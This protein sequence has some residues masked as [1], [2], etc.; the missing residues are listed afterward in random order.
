M[1]FVCTPAVLRLIGDSI[2]RAAD[3]GVD[4]PVLA[5][6]LVVSLISG[7][8]F[9]I[10]PALTA[11]KTDLVSTLKEGGYSDIPSHDW[12]RSTVIVGQVALG[13]VLT[14]GAG[15]LVTSFVKLMRMNEG[16]NP[17]RLLTFTFELPDSAYKDKRPEF[18]RQYFEKLRALPGVQSAAGA[19]NLPM[20]DNLAMI[21]F[22]NPEH[23]VPKGQQP[24]ADFTYVSADYFRTLQVPLLYGRAFSDSDDMKAP[25]VMIVNRAFVQ[26]YFPGGNVL[27]KKLKPGATNGMPGGPP[28]R[29]IVG[30]VDNIRHFGTQREMPPAMYLPVGQLPTWCCLRFVV[31]TSMDPMRLE[32]AVRRLVSSLDPNLPV[33]EVRSMDDLLSLQLAQPRIAMILLGTFAGLALLLTMV[34]LYGVMAYSVSRRTREIG[35]RLA[36]GAQRSA[37]MAMVLRDAAVLLLVGIAFGAAA[38]FAS[39]SAL[40]T[41]L[42]SVNPHDP[43]VL[44]VVCISVALTGLLAA[45]IPSVRAASID[46]MKAL[47]RE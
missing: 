14:V 29:E 13:I 32:P 34:G 38:S 2:P 11:S 12:L 19:H 22:G 27:G 7:V 28:L 6:A 1:A 35:V 9:G 5:F 33:T 24:N 31:R 47:R 21:G 30:V 23:P 8:V 42:Y 36:L 43:L 4:L 26:Q 20:T 25:Q 17:D 37:V 16:F 45:Y 15:L 10:F 46:P 18:Y 44:A 40:K 41:T 39:A 3:A